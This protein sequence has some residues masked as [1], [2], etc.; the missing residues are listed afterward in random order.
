MGSGMEYHLGLVGLKDLIQACFI[1][2]RAYDDIRRAQILA[3]AQA[4][5]IQKLICCVFINI[6]DDE[7]GGREGAYLTADLGAYGAA[8]ARYEHGPALYVGEDALGIQLHLFPCE[9]IGYLQLAYGGSHVS[10]HLRRGGEDIDAPPG[11]I[12]RFGEPAH[13]LAVHGGNGDEYGIDLFLFDD[14]GEVSDRAHDGETMYMHA[15]LCRVVIEEGNGIAEAAGIGAAHVHGICA[16]ISRADDEHAFALARLCMLSLAAD[17]PVVEEPGAYDEREGKHSR[18]HKMAAA[19][20]DV[21]EGIDAYGDKACSNAGDDEAYDLAHACI[22]PKDTVL[23]PQE[24]T[25]RINGQDIGDAFVEGIALPGGHAALE[26][27]DRSEPYGKP[28]EQHV[29]QEHAEHASYDGES[30]VCF[31]TKSSLS[32]YD[33]RRMRFTV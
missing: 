10:L 14:I 32:V 1:P 15:L 3:Q 6:E 11:G 7:P 22:A 26:P 31:H 8:A 30:N 29:E 25:G 20:I 19:H 17:V 18:Q 9:E 13:I 28:G 21:R 27:D 12:G 33:D 5:V 23:A 2:D 4:K 24:I 16:G